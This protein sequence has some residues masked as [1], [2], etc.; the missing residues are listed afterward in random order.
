MRKNKNSEFAYSKRLGIYILKKTNKDQVTKDYSKYNANF[1][2][3]RGLGDTTPI[4]VTP[5]MVVGYI[6]LLFSGKFNPVTQVDAMKK[7]MVKNG[8]LINTDRF[9]HIRLNLE[10]LCK[11]FNLSNYLQQKRNQ[12]KLNKGRIILKYV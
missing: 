11:D 10:K 3:V 7:Q 5:R 12:T 8:L 6:D 4:K 1:N 9:L 2:H